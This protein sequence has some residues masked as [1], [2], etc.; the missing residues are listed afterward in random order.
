VLKLPFLVARVEQRRG[1]KWN[2]GERIKY[3]P[4]RLLYQLLYR[5][6]IFQE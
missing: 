6:I 2:K 5:S 3:C 1:T 4:C